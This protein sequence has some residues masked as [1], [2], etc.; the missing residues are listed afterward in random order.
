MLQRNL[1]RSLQSFQNWIKFASKIVNL[2]V[3]SI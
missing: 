2:L 3:I 1:V